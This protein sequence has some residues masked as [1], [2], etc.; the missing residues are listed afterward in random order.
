MIKQA[1]RE[2]AIG[3]MAKTPKKSR[4]IASHGRFRP[5]FLGFSASGP[6]RPPDLAGRAT[7]GIARKAEA[8]NDSPERSA[9]HQECPMQLG[10]PRRSRQAQ[11][12]RDTSKRIAGDGHGW[13]CRPNTY[14]RW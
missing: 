5:V 8:K 12:R 1:F 11:R 9:A 10:P 2:K 14:D 6:C 4:K 3:K 13:P 7:V